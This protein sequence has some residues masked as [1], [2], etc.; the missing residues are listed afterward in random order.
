MADVMTVQRD[1]TVRLRFDVT[2]D[3]TEFAGWAEQ[4]GLRTVQSTVETAIATVLRLPGARLTV[5]GRTDAGVHACGQVC[6]ADVESSAL[7]RLGGPDR[8]AQRL[9]RLL[10]ADVRVFRVGAAPAGFDARF[11]AL[12]RRYAYRVS[13]DPATADPLHR[14]HVLT[15]PRRVDEA[16]MNTAAERLAGEHDFAA[17][18]KR[19][20]GATTIRSLHELV[21]ERQAD[22]LT[23]RVVGDA[24]CHRMVR[25]LVGC[26]IAVGERKRPVS[27]PADVL[28]ARV[29]HPGVLVVPARGLTLEEVGYPPDDK[30]ATRARESRTRRTLGE[31]H[32]VPCGTHDASA[33]GQEEK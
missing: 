9:G 33:T 2:Y 30:L 18:C 27:W 14:R 1:S 15:W 22:R 4:P 31:A 28:A 5:A 6:H 16:L 11:S 17:F 3:G 7:D 26:L 19:R 12:F 25:S 23:C 10:P 20:E 21:W 24:F 13:D 8:L 29:R 32:H